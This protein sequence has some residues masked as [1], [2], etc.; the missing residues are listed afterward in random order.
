VFLQVPFSAAGHRFKL[1][2]LER[3]SAACPLPNAPSNQPAGRN[4]SKRL[5]PFH[6]IWSCHVDS[7]ILLVSTFACRTKKLTKQDTFG[8]N[9]TR[10]LKLKHAVDNSLL[11][12]VQRLSMVINQ[13][14]N[15]FIILVLRTHLG[16]N[17][18]NVKFE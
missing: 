5:K 17:S 3:S 6:E 11:Y 4:S 15:Q 16:R 10:F 18:E 13:S 2:D 1:L 7:G 9:L 14:I 12:V 8:T